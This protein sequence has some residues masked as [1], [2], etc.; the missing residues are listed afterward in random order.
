[1]ALINLWSYSFLRNQNSHLYL[2]GS[3]LQGLLK[4]KQRSQAA[5]RKTTC[6]DCRQETIV[7]G[8]NTSGLHC[9]VDKFWAQSNSTKANSVCGFLR[10]QLD[11]LLSHHLLTKNEAC[12]FAELSDFQLFMLENKNQ[13][14]SN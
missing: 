3:A 14:F 5:I 13:S 2:N 9:I 11:F 8:Y 4:V 12:R 1:M 10:G 7:D 6:K